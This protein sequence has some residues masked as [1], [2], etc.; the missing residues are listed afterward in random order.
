MKNLIPTNDMSNLMRPRQI[1]VKSLMTVDSHGSQAILYSLAFTR[2]KDAVKMLEWLK[3]K[4]EERETLAIHDITYMMGMGI[5]LPEY[6]THF[7]GCEIS[8]DFEAAPKPLG[9]DPICGT[10]WIIDL[11]IIVLDYMTTF[12]YTMKTKEEPAND[13]SD[14]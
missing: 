3:R 6:L 7:C 4:Q 1:M 8:F 11:P 5:G 13:D 12:P 14:Q 2:K 9:I 10:A